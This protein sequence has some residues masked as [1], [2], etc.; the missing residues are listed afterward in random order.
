[1]NRMFYE[2]AA[3]SFI[4]GN[5][6]WTCNSSNNMFYGCI[7]LRGAIS[8][9]D[10]K[11]DVTYANPTAGYFTAYTRSDPDGDGEISNKDAEAVGDHIL[12]NTPEGFI[13]PAADSNG[14]GKVNVADIVDII[15]KKE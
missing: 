12:G 2:C 13:A 6:T 5:D 11:I 8:Y 1:M 9:D 15:N 10:S 14:D 4:Y 7:S 3:L